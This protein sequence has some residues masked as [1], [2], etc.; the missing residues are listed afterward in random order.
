MRARIVDGIIVQNRSVPD[1]VILGDKHLVLIVI[2]D[3]AYG[4]GDY[5]SIGIDPTVG[6][7]HRHNRHRAGFG[8]KDVI[9]DLV[10]PIIRNCSTVVIGNSRLLRSTS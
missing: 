3:V 5:V 10:D 9:F 8:G 2:V 6:T 4:D 7:Q 1:R